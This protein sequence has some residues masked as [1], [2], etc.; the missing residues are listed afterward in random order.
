MEKLPYGETAGIVL[1]DV[2]GLKLI[3]D[4]FGHDQGDNLLIA[5]A[6]VIRTSFCKEDLVARIGGD[7]FAILLPKT[8]ELT[9]ENACQR[10]QETVASYNATHPELPLS[11]SVGSAVNNGDYRNVKDLFKEADMIMYREKLHRIQ[12][13]RSKIINTLVDTLKAKNFVSDQHAVHLEKLIANMATFIRLPESTATNLSLLARFYDIGKVGVSDSILLKKG[14]LTPEEWM[15]MKRHCEIGYRIAMLTPELAPIADW[16]L[17]HHEWWNGQGYPL[18]I[19][20]EEIPIECRLFAIADAYEAMVNVRPYRRAF[21]HAEAIAELLR[22][23]GTQF[24]PKL[25][26]IFLQLLENHPPQSGSTA[27]SAA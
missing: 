9:V 6:R 8:T 5:A 17:K 18:G 16:I 27:L 20:E 19:K 10:I 12:S 22:L 7:E 15:E 3:N 24:D 4:T 25:L 11:I 21:S 2:D 23:S 26:D 13:I 1:C 14:S